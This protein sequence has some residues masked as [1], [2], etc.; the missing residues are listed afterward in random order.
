LTICASSSAWS[1]LMSGS[2]SRACD[3]TRPLVTDSMRW[4]RRLQAFCFHRAGA[5]RASAHQQR[6][7]VDVESRLF[8][9]ILLAVEGRMRLQ[10]LIAY[11]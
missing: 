5:E 9:Q 7:Q 6:L 11:E 3:R 4:D 1:A 8:S 2:A 10:L